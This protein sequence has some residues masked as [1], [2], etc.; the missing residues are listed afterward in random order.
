MSE[1]DTFSVVPTKVV[2]ELVEALR[3]L[4][5]AVDP[6]EPMRPLSIAE[7][8]K[9]LRCRRSEV[10]KLIEDG[11]MPYIRRNDRRYVLPS[12][13][14]QWLRNES[15]RKPSKRRINSTKLHIDVEDIDPAL[16]KFFD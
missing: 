12:V 14:G 16:R 8:A 5:N 2:E 13:V 15:A 9:V 3:D 1:H 4:R 10:E 6:I 7:A 11:A